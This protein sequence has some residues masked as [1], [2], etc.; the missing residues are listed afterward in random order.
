MTKKWHSVANQGLSAIC[1]TVLYRLLFYDK[2][3]KELFSHT[4]FTLDSV[5]LSATM[6]SNDQSLIYSQEIEKRQ[7]LCK[8][9]IEQL[10]K[11]KNN[12]LK[13]FSIL[14]TSERIIKK[15]SNKLYN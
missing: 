14:C 6:A 15:T 5:A 9:I 4:D 12:I 7:T 8:Q 2:Q 10:H 3:E 1:Q 13:G 11:D